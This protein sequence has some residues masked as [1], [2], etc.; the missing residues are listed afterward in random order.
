LPFG[1]SDKAYFKFDEMNKC[2]E[3]LKPMMPL[4]TEEFIKYKGDRKKCRFYQP[5]KENE[6]RIL[7][8]D[9]AMM[10]G[11]EN[12]NTA[13]TLIRLL[14]NGDEYIK[15]VSYLEITN[16]ENTATQALRLK[17]L[18]YD[19]ECDYVAMDAAG[20]GLGVYDECTRIIVDTERGVEYPAWMSMNDDKM[21]ERAIDKNAL[22]IIHSIKVS[23]GNA[24]ETMHQM[25]V[26]AKTQFEKRKIKL[27]VSEI[28][29]KDYL[30]EQYN[31]ANLEIEEQAELLSIY[32]N[33]SKLINEAINLEKEYKRGFIKL[34]EMAGRRKDRIYSLLYGLYYARM[35][36]QLLLD[37]ITDDSDDDV[38]LY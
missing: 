22:P 16:G 33:C 21:K 6:I 15:I 7:A 5:K 9:I 17:R 11:L 8:M 26:Y 4:T 14:P 3:I 34:N 24:I 13:F 18:F 27:P 37:D 20:N 10:V 23:G 1:E 2:R 19:L 30:I 38:I 31:Y 25:Y 32:I 29:A 12:D 36:E 28:S 35:L